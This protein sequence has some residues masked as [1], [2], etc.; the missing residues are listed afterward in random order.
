M[1]INNNYCIIM[2][3]GV[4]SR[5]WPLSR[6]SVPKQFLDIIGVG[7]TF[8][9]MTVSRFSRI[10]PLENIYVVTS[11]L[12][13]DLIE[14]QIPEIPKENILYEP[15]KRNTA[16]C[17]AYATYKL[18]DKNPDATVVITPSDHLI[19]NDSVFEDCIKS[20][21]EYASCHD[22]LFTI[23]V[24][25]T[26]PNTNYGYIQIDKND[27]VELNGTNMNK[28]K[29]FTEKPNSD[30][31]KVFYETGEF[32]WNSGMFIWNLKTI[33]QELETHLPGVATLFM[34]GE[35][36]Y[37]TP[38]EKAFILNVY[39]NSTSISIDYGVMEKT[40]LA[41]VYPASF[42]WSD[43]GTWESLYEISG[44]EQ[45]ADKNLSRV[46]NQLFSNCKGSVFYEKNK[47][48]LLVAKDLKD[49]MVI[50]TDD[51]LMVCPRNDAAIKEILVSLAVEDKS[52][53]L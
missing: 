15:Y 10:L 13:K 41:W 36:K 25:P 52:K 21:M 22:E 53:Y 7:K 5:F 28:I 35:G 30:L 39:E 29:T 49:Y 4:G 11:V 50:D 2:A 33:K 40:Q 16:P 17:V 20:V 18:Y 23:G 31:A 3:G 8:L 48:K 24:R 14:A 27:V 47:G 32:Y 9:Q 37:N 26:S 38:A 45:D 19:I 34:A 51:V 12:Y 44:S 42:G 46:E 1:D 6:N 43:V